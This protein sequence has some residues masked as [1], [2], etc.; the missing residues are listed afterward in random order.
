MIQQ[1]LLALCIVLVFLGYLKIL[2]MYLTNKGKK[3]DT[4]ASEVS[5][6]ILD[7][8]TS[9]N[10]IESKE[11]IFSKYNIKR[12]M[13]KLSSNTYDS[14][15]EFSKSISTLLS[16]YAISNNKYLN[17]ISK[18]FKELKF[19]SYSPILAIIISILTTN[20]T[21]AK[22]GIILLILIAIYQYTLYTINTE[23]MDKIKLKDKKRNKILNNLANMN[24]LFFVVT[25]IQIIRLV[26]IILKI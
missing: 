6:K 14:S 10:L 24:I 11:S 22:I 16:G 4:T 3:T 25:L 5:L 1:I 17:I 7:D 12:K 2:I 8:E 23:A 15:D 9:I 13:V 20:I 26:V 21:D 19:F 18:I